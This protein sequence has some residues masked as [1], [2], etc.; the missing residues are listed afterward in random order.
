MFIVDPNKIKKET[1]FE[2][3]LPK[4]SY[5][6]PDPLLRSHARGMRSCNCPYNPESRYMSMPL[7][8]G[9][10]ISGDVRQRG[11]LYALSSTL[12]A[13]YNQKGGVSALIKAGTGHGKTYYIMA[14]LA[15]LLGE[16][17]NCWVYFTAPVRTQLDQI[18]EKHTPDI[19]Y[20]GNE[21]M[22]P[23]EDPVIRA[24]IYDKIDM[25]SSTTKDPLTGSVKPNILIID[26]GQ[27]IITEKNYREIM[28]T[29]NKKAREFLMEGGIVIVITA[30]TELISVTMPYNSLSSYD[31]ICNMFTVSSDK[32][33]KTDK[34]EIQYP[35][36]T[37]KDVVKYGE[38]SGVHIVNA[39][40]AH[41]IKVM[42]KHKEDNVKTAALN[43]IIELLNDKRK[44]LMEYNDKKCLREI[45]LEL[46]NQGYNVVV[47]TADD[48][49]YTYDPQKKTKT[50]TKEI[51]N[52][53]IY[54]R[55]IDYTKS[56][57]VLTTK[58]LENGTSI[59]KILG[60]W[61][62]PAAKEAVKNKITTV[63]V[64]NKYTDMNIE[65]FEQ[66]AGRIRFKYAEAILLT[67]VPEEQSEE[68]LNKDINDVI[69][70]EI[71]RVKDLVA[72]LEDGVISMNRLSY[73]DYKDSAD[74]KESLTPYGGIDAETICQAV[75]YAYRRY[76]I[77]LMYDLKAFK[78]EITT[79][80]KYKDVSFVHMSKSKAKLSSKPLPFSEDEKQLLKDAIDEAA[81]NPEIR[82]LYIKGINNHSQDSKEVLLPG[83]KELAD[84]G[85]G[86]L[87][88]S[89]AE[90]CGIELALIEL[91]SEGKTDGISP[92]GF[93]NNVVNSLENNKNKGISPL[94]RKGISEGFA[95]LSQYK[96]L[97]TP[98][99]NH[100][101]TY[102][103]HSY[104]NDT[105]QL[106]KKCGVLLPSSLDPR[107]R[108]R[109]ID[110]MRFL[111]KSDIKKCID[112]HLY[113]TQDVSCNNICKDLTYYE[114]MS[115]FSINEINHTTFLI[116]MTHFSIH[117]ESV[118]ADNTESGAFFMAIT[119]RYVY[120]KVSGKD[121]SSYDNK[122]AGNIEYWSGLT[123]SRERV[124]EIINV[125]NVILKKQ[126][127]RPIKGDNSSILKVL[128]LFAACFHYVRIA[129][130]GKDAKMYSIRLDNIR[131]KYPSDYSDIVRLSFKISHNKDDDSIS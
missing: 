3:M 61:D 123:L 45:Q 8:E 70:G 108:E 16:M 115:K 12:I 22:E 67:G 31:L 20:S 24:Y 59:D 87:I 98:L 21:I 96:D 119:S 74:L 122:Q 66:F 36:Y 114:K 84:M 46:I 93:S 11:N 83:L 110:L 104:D 92:E 43:V 38:G 111:F 44:I 106:I 94:L 72:L 121:L 13:G 85:K 130:K 30:S 125:G 69:H 91:K 107:I 58:L 81:T 7:V 42:F 26:E 54:D 64:F 82:N 63:Y 95:Y 32:P 78:K 120:E 86:Y 90:V 5:N 56:D 33:I 131:T 51:I 99:Y 126:G 88:Q 50:Y 29:V 52:N 4:D 14:E 76:Y 101:L 10:Y 103:T 34:G 102:G 68:G 73:V 15:Q 35:N 6:H 113:I 28:N 19:C 49:E 80:F 41:K 124:I 53:I 65:A 97:Y 27:F 128:R 55:G 129:P 60:E 18:K 23:G 127:H 48:K 77:G 1:V 116:E 112:R 39:I 2:S 47:L 105:E 17:C 79:R 118:L 109:V 57:V 75:Y 117:P 100:A 37:Y 9:S 89:T 71:R 62:S 40:P 25:V